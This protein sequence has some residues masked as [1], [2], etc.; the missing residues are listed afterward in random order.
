MEL[1]EEV[2]QRSKE[3]IEQMEQKVR[4]IEQR[5]KELQ[6]Y[7]TARNIEPIQASPETIRRVFEHIGETLE[8]SK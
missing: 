2:D 7:L 5:V 6:A 8:Q 4:E 3:R 1:M